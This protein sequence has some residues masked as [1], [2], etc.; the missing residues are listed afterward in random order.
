MKVGIIGTGMI[1]SVFLDTFQKEGS[2]HVEGLWCLDS[3]YDSA[4]EL[5]E[6]YNVQ[7]LETDIDRFLA[8]DR[9]DTVYIAVINSLHYEFAKKS[10]LAGKNVLCEKP[11]TTTYVQAKELCELAKEKGVMLIDCI[12]ARYSENLVPLKEAISQIGDVKMAHVVYS[13]Y[14]RRYDKYLEGEILPVF[15]VDLA[16]GA[17]Y[18]LNVYNLSLIEELFGTPSTY[19]YYP[20]KGYNGI[21]VSGVMMLDY[22]DKKVV[23]A[24]AKDCGGQQQAFIQGTKGYIRIDGIPCYLKNM[25]LVMNGQEP[26]KIDVIDYSNTRAHMFKNINVMIE[27]REM[28]K[29]SKMLKKTLSTM[30]L[31]ESARKETGIFFGEGN[32]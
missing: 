10:L 2:I 5:A 29:A 18:D 17:L 32:D 6:K 24:T 22:G 30:K 28:D 9:F 8:N 21:D 15:S 7:I 12:P 13:Q 27:N 31:M 16:G 14:S 3:L 11:F 26:V 1:A 23:S 25:Y 20:N 19:K 4:K